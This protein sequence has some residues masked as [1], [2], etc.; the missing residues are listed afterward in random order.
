MKRLAICL[1]GTTALL[2]AVS[3][4]ASKITEAAAARKHLPEFNVVCG[5]GFASHDYKQ[6]DAHLL[7]L[8]KKAPIT[9]TPAENNQLNC[10]FGNNVFVQIQQASLGTCKYYA[11]S[12]QKSLCLNITT[13]ISS[14]NSQ[15]T[16]AYTAVINDSM[17]VA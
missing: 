17:A 2:T 14:I 12:K 1:L 8:V 11:Q 7:K 13:A 4:Y 9:T 10:L 6:L 5:D 16:L 15:G 3:C